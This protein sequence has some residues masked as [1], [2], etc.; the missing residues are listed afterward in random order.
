[1]VSFPIVTTLL[2]KIHSMLHRALWPKKILI[3]MKCVCVCLWE[4]ERRHRE[5]KRERKSS[6]TNVVSEKTWV[7]L[8]FFL[9]PIT[10]VISSCHIQRLVLKFFWILPFTFFDSSNFSR[11]IL[12]AWEEKFTLTF[13]RM[14]HNIW[15]WWIIKSASLFHHYT[16]HQICEEK[17]K[18]K[19]DRLFWCRQLI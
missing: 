14:V 18:Q 7:F 16:E 10:L 5:R 2:C 19:N 11:D 4:R 17:T 9:G 6:V 3:E 8:P 1:M 13:T 12:R 15:Y